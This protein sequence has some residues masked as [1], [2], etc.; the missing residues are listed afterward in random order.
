[1]NDPNPRHEPDELDLDAETVSDLD[2]PGDDGADLGG[3]RLPQNTG[4][5]HPERTVAC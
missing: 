3:G 4:L 1:M 2:V 5:C